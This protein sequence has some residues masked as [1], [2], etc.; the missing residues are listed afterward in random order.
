MFRLVQQSR[1]FSG[2]GKRVS[3]IAIVYSRAATGVAFGPIIGPLSLE[4]GRALTFSMLGFSEFLMAVLFLMLSRA[5][6]KTAQSLPVLRRY[7]DVSKA[8]HGFWVA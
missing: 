1:I 3:A 7:L 4:L 8:A 5:S 6:S 2:S